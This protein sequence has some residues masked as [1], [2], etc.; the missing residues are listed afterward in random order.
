MEEETPGAGVS[1]M[2]FISLGAYRKRSL[3]GIHSPSELPVEFLLEWYKD[4]FDAPRTHTDEEL[5]EMSQLPPASRLAWIEE[6]AA[7]TWQARIGM[8]REAAF[9]SPV[10]ANVSLMRNE[11]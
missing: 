8:C 11:R 7:F 4:M 3:A 2:D 10:C 9:N 6:M 1:C 5:V